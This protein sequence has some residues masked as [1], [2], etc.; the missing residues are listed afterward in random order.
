M[1]PT[2]QRLPHLPSQFSCFSCQS[3]FRSLGN[4]V[5]NIL[6]PAKINAKRRTPNQNMRKNEHANKKAIHFFIASHKFY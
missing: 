1:A 6:G 5:G 3:S 2:G 4:F